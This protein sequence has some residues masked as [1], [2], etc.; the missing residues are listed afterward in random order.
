MN[1]VNLMPEP[2]SERQRIACATFVFT[3]IVGSTALAERVGDERWADVLRAHNRV[4]RAI[5]AAA[6]GEEVAFLGDGFL[7]MFKTPTAA[8]TCAQRLLQAMEALHIRFADAPVEL[9]IGIHCGEAFRDG[10]DI[11]G[12]AVHMASRV[13][14]AAG[15]GEIAVSDACHELVRAEAPRFWRARERTLKGLPGRHRLFISRPG[16]VLQPVA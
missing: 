8:W 7:L 3:D 12:R 15:A 14:D 6:G 16:L 4:V 2:L 11:F 9:R 10:G 13:A 5:V 1:V